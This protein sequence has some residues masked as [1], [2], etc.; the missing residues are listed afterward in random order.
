[1]NLKEL[2]EKLASK[3]QE[4]ADLVAKVQLEARAFTEEEDK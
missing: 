1:M 2:N 3:K 4:M